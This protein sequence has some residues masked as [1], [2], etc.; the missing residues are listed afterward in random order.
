MSKT[1]KENLLQSPH[2]HT[3]HTVGRGLTWLHP[4]QAPRQ[5]HCL[6]GSGPGGKSRNDGLVVVGKCVC[7]SQP[8]RS[9][10]KTEVCAFLQLKLCMSYP[11][12]QVLSFP[13]H[14]PVSTKVSESIQT[15]LGVLAED[16]Q[17]RRELLDYLRPQHP[18]MS[19]HQD[20][21]TGP[22]CRQY[23]Q[24]HSVLREMQL[25]ECCPLSYGG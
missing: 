16:R 13:E 9:Q 5:W 24:G 11:L 19:H 2:T 23:P 6:S 17:T 1:P 12:P 21:S 15:R 20:L 10:R 4:L 3:Q 8:E 18:R 7:T 25:T 14:S 22:V